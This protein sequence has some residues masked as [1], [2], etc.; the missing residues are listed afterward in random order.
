[1]AL[2]VEA[3]EVGAFLVERYVAAV[4]VVD[5]HAVAAKLV[6]RYVVA[7]LAASCQVDRNAGVEIATD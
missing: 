7:V 1:M 2:Y 4:M 6:E 5:Y 3:A